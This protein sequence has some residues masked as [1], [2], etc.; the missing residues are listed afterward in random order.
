MRRKVLQASRISKSFGSCKA[1]QNV[2][3]EL[4]SGEVLGIAG[5]NGS[6]K[7]TLIKIIS[8][9]HRV[10]QGI[11]E[12]DGKEYLPESPKDSESLGIHVFHQEIP[13][14]LNLTIAENLYLSPS[15]PK[16]TYFLNKEV[17]NLKAERLFK[18]VLGEEIDA[19][20]KMI[21][22]SISVR[23]LT[24]LVKALYGNPK[25]II[26]DEP[27]TALTSTE[28]EHLFSIIN[29]L[30]SKGISFIFISHMLDEI[31]S[32]CDRVMVL[33]DGC[34][35]SEL[36]KGNYSRS[37]LSYQIAG[38]TLHRK[39]KQSESA[40]QNTILQLRDYRSTPSSPKV[41]IDLLKGEVV[42]LAGLADSGRSELLSSIFGYPVPG[43]GEILIN[44]DIST[45]RNCSDA[46][47][48]GIAY[49]PPDRKLQGIF[50]SHDI[51]FNIGVSSL[52]KWV[53][54]KFVCY[55]KLNDV[56]EF[57]QRLMKIKCTSMSENLTNLSGGNQ[58]KAILARMFTRTPEIML[59]N[60]PT[61]G[62]DV[63]AKEEI[64]KLILDKSREGYSFIITS[65]EIDEI[66]SICDSIYVMKKGNIV[67][68]LSGKEV[69]KNNIIKY[70]S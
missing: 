33:R 55:D 39:Q 62:I 70:S 17:M 13:V 66:T 14:F 32:L 50:P 22:V 1:L 59:L 61:R 46:L 20:K 48:R 53:K 7:S 3:F 44:G 10:D 63:G 54:N 15:F 23:Q 47:N 42:G 19:S 38:K 4:H 31:M 9:V 34:Q 5:E 35:V 64:M 16:E 26:L 2:N 36:G 25:V 6:G 57:Y 12:L 68:K 49:L 60:E 29:T 11:L 37:E 65:S 28:V 30:K 56:S 45:I 67:T 21:D 43:V 69:T 58:Q 27:T 51:R 18:E 8:G 24:L 40:S 41:S 52:F